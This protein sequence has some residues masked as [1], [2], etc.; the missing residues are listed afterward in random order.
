MKQVGFCCKNDKKEELIYS[1]EV[2]YRK[3]KNY[4]KELINYFS[5]LKH[6]PVSEF[7]KL[8]KVVVK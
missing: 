4:F 7:K 3:T 1:L 5:Q 8:Y 6:L 2:N